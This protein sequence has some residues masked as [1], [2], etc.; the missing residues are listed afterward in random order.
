MSDTTKK[1][2]KEKNYENFEVKKEIISWIKAGI[3]TLIFYL[4]VN[5]FIFTAKVDGPSML[6]T[7]EHGD[8]ILVNRIAYSLDNSLPEYEDVIIF[9]NEYKGYELIKRVIGLPGDHIEIKEGKV[10]RNGTLLTEIYLDTSI[11]PNGTEGNV[12]EII[13]EGHVFVM[14]D[15]RANSADSRYPEIG[16]IN[17]KDVKGKVFLRM[18]PNFKTF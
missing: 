2:E 14:G 15:N 4:F 3:I 18:I 7:F 1:V 12:D 5:I 9:T 16:Q 13:N 6:S 8:L 10:Y 17:M 11:L